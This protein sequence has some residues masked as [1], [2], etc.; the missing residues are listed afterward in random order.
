MAILRTIPKNVQDFLASPPGKGGTH[1][2]L[3]KAAIRLKPYLPE[4]G[5]YECLRKTVEQK[6][7]HRTVPSR[8][9]CDAI[10]FATTMAG[11]S[12]QAKPAIKWPQADKDEIQRVLEKVPPLTWDISPPGP[13]RALQAL[14]S[15][16]ELICYGPRKEL[17][18]IACAGNLARFAAEMQFIVPNPMRAEFGLTTSGKFS[19]R[20][21]A[22]VLCRKHL[23][24]EIDDEFLGKERQARILS[25]LA[26]MV[27]LRMVV[28]SGGKSLHGWFDVSELGDEG[29]RAFFEKAVLLG[30][31]RHMWA[32]SQW[33]RM[34]GGKR[35]TD[36]G[37]VSQRILYFRPRVAA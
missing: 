31:D 22:N 21:N 33:T 34:P 1:N 27:P 29:T 15:P 24:V 7:H 35:Q 13:G 6:V 8:E 30:A 3:V 32:L 28:D 4:A 26:G 11:R 36:T 10:V 37:F 9:I 20:C 17:A 19:A 2:W 12:I 18:K 5:I 16:T 25:F 23:I 14:F